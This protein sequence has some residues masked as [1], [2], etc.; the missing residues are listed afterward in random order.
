M[1]LSSFR[2]F[3]LRLVLAAS[4][5][6]P[7]SGARAQSAQPELPIRPLSAGIYLIQA[8]M[9]T[10]GQERELGLMYRTELPDNHGMAFV[11]D[12]PAVQCMWM[13]NTLIPLSVAFMDAQGRILNIEEM[14][15]QT[16]TDHC[17]KGNVV[18]AL[19]MGPGWFS[20]RHIK[21]G[22]VISGLPAPAQ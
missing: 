14:A 12:Y 5:V 17:S 16:L 8:E 7:A 1:A 3:P 4:L 13:K 22:T 2:R 20:R 21:P 6:V 19:E 15:P 9:A 10:T 18:Y 11:F